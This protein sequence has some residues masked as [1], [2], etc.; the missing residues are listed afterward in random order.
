M[1]ASEAE[2]SYGLE[3]HGIYNVGEVHWN[4]RTTVLYEHIIRRSEGQI[5]HLG[6]VLVRTGIHT[7]RAAKDRYVVQDPG[8]DD[9]WW[10]PASRP[11][12]AERFEELLHR[13][14]AYLQ[15]H[16]LYVQ[17]CYAGAD[18]RYRVR[19]RV[20]NESAWHNLFARTMFVRAPLEDLAD[21]V[22]E[23]TVIHAPSFHAVPE[24]D[25][26]DSP[27]FVVLNLA[28]RMVLIGGTSYA[29][30]IK[31]AVFSVINYLLP[32]QGV[33]SMHASANVG[34]QGDAALFFGLSGTGK[35]T[36]STD[37][38]RLLI[39]DD[40]H[41]WSDR[42]IF[43]IE[44]GCYAKVIRLSA[45]SE[46]DIWE[47][48]RR[49]GTILENVSFDSWT[50]RLNYDDDTLTENT[51]AAYPITH[52]RNVVEEG[53]AG[54]PRN[55]VFLTADAFGV[56]P[57][58][59]KLSADQAM[60]HFMSGYTSKLA[61]TEK[62]LGKEPQATFS[63]CFG[64]PF[65]LL[66]PYEYAKLLADKI[67]D[68]NVDCW[69]VNTGWTGG[70][71]GIGHRMSIGHTRALVRAALSGALAKTPTRTEPY[72]GLA[73]PERCEG[74]PTEVLDPRRTWSDEAAYDMKARQLAAQFRQ[75]FHQ[76]ESVVSRE[77]RDAGP[78]G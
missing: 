21:F 40:E 17:D 65:M 48:T 16:D 44:G 50:R 30:E 20:I 2:S 9:V 54:H 7:G 70:P 46:P 4:L 64:Q 78:K 38:D 49:F 62:G 22:P 11:L 34:E 69:L 60:Y 24:I 72:F 31:K 10:N 26:T 73:I 1:K 76:F 37:R 29:G 39:G 19:L 51:R 58:I 68:H 77:V 12:S 5:A 8:L 74:V 23:L 6:P 18:P 32:K 15:G 67:R 57:P 47:A 59:A 66:H 41:G 63:A 71:F 36:L 56:M 33:L 42:G 43:N 55:I 14:L 3:H 25:G 75:N 45:E 27:T 13:M 35:T 52:I 53:M 28:K 61:G